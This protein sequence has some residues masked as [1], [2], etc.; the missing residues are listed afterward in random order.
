MKKNINRGRPKGSKNPHQGEPNN[1]SFWKVTIKNREVINAFL[2]RGSEKQKESIKEVL[3]YLKRADKKEEEFR[4]RFEQADLQF[5]E[6]VSGKEIL[7][8]LNA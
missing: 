4:N 2:D 1:L 3:I 7:K 5:F 8:E 6:K